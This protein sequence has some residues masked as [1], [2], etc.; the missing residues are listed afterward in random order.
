MFFFKYFMLCYVMLLYCVV[1]C[2]IIVL[3]CSVCMLVYLVPCR[4]SLLGCGYVWNIMES[5]RGKNNLQNWRHPHEL[6]YHMGWIA[7]ACHHWWWIWHRCARAWLGGWPWFRAAAKLGEGTWPWV[8][9]RW[10][11]LN[12]SKKRLEHIIWIYIMH[13]NIIN[14]PNLMMCHFRSTSRWLKW[15]N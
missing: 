12:S 2:C 8:L 5:E 3:H 13:I 11:R 14:I 9:A 1:S 6:I 4:L 7:R 10:P 15:F